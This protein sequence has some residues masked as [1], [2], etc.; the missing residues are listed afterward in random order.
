MGKLMRNRG[1]VVLAQGRHGET[2]ARLS[3]GRVVLTGIAVLGVLAALPSGAQAAP[4]DLDPS[5]GT[6][7]LVTDTFGSNSAAYGG[8]V[9]LDTAGRIIVAGAS[10]GDLAVARYTPAGVLDLSFG[11]GDGVATTGF[12]VGT[13]TDA[14]AVAIDAS[15]RIV[16][17]GHT[18]PDFVC[19]GDCDFGIVRFTESGALDS[20]FGGGDGKVA[21]G[22]EPGTHDSVDD[23]AIDGSGRIIVAGTTIAE[24]EQSS[25]FA[26]V[27]LDGGGTLDST[28][29][30]D[31]KVIAS[32]NGGA[33]GLVLDAAGRLVLAGIAQG[34][35]AVARFTSAGSPDSSFDGDGVVKTAGSP[36]GFDSPFDVGIDSDGR[37]VVIGMSSPSGGGTFPLL[38][39]YMPGGALDP[40]FGGGDGLVVD[41]LSETG[42]AGMTFDGSGRIVTVG[43]SQPVG[44][45]SDFAVL[46]YTASGSR[47]PSFGG[48]DGVVTTNFGQSTFSGAGGVLVDSA[49]RLV[50]AGNTEDE[51]TS[52]FALARYQGDEPTPPPPPVESSIAPSSIQQV[53]TVSGPVHKRKKCKRGFRKKRVRG[54]TRCVRKKKERKR[55]L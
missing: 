9:A 8:A 51:G 4:G 37:I 42:L 21:I 39:R 24:D 11:G 1:D 49:G 26:L 6:G 35:V 48:G 13:M 45:E 15:G 34:E 17:A 52:A 31:G 40:T 7:G 22:I 29:D 18:G 5:F 32:F 2:Q 50:A 30:G 38:L 14:V 3:I 46:R 44:S 41:D 10:D 47:D 27:R 16:A 54:K 43:F 19:S 33:A 55:G 23:L 28:F 12:G 53:P 36:G 25:A 20:A